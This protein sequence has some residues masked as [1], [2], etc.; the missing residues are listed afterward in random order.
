MFIVEK[1]IISFKG[2][3]YFVNKK[4]PKNLSI[5]HLVT[6]KN[7]KLPI[8][9]ATFVRKAHPEELEK[10]WV[11]KVESVPYLKE[12]MIVKCSI[13]KL[14]AHSAYV[15]T[16]VNPST[17]TVFPLFGGI[18]YRVSP[19]SLKEMSAAELRSIL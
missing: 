4:M 9:A 17:T 7:Y 18:G 16:K 14:T 1:H 19:S 12:G 11:A 2:E 8:A 5:T 10:F 6:G 3:E 13:P 15:V